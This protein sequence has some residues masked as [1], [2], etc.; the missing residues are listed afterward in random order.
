MV[1]SITQSVAAPP[2]DHPAADGAEL[3]ADRPDRR[4]EPPQQRL[5]VVGPG[6]GGEV[7]VVAEPAEQRVADAAAD[8]VQLVPG[9]GEQLAQPVDHGGDPDQLGHRVALASS[10][11]TP[12]AEPSSGGVADAGRVVGTRVQTTGGAPAPDARTRNHA[13]GTREP[14]P[15][16]RGLG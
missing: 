6:G 16:S 1:T 14:G 7:Q 10:R 15:D 5:D 9:R 8:Q 3:L 13:A 2:V 4:G 12:G 11:A